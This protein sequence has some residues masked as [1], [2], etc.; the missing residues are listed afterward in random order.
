MKPPVARQDRKP[1]TPEELEQITNSS[2]PIFPGYGT[3]GFAKLHCFLAV[4]LCLAPCPYAR[5]NNACPWGGAA[6]A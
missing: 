6:L 2:T 4:R 5:S 1:G 3:C